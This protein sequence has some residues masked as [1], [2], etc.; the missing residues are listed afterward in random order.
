M[1]LQ[2]YQAVNREAIWASLFAY[3]QGKLWAPPWVAGTAY[4][5][6]QVVTDPQGHLQ[7]VTTAGTSGATAPAWNDAGGTTPDLSPL[8]W[9]DTGPGFVSMGRRHVAP[10]DLVTAAQPAMFLIQVKEQHAPRPRGVPTKLV[11]HGYLILYVPAPVADEDIGA[12]TV[13]AATTLN[14]LYQAIDAALEPDNV[15]QGVFTIGGLVSH[16]WIE[17]DTD[18]DP[19]IFGSQAAAIL[20]IHILVP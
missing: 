5:L 2:Q 10:P 16:C 9:T 1:T 13:L 19:G 17:G 15:G 4:T 3:F 6:G 8:V 7:K 12:E 18:Q 14:Q 20:P 11:L